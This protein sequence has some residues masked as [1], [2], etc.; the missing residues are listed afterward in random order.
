MGITEGVTEF[1][2]I[3][4]TGHMV[5]VAHILALAE[6]NFVKSFEI[7]IQLGAIAA[8]VLLYAKRVLK[9]WETMKKVLTAFV[10]TGIIG[11]VLYKL[12]KQY[13][14]GNVWVTVIAL[15]A[16]GAAIILL[17][18]KMKITNNRSHGEQLPITNLKDLSYKKAATIGVIQ[19]ISVIPGVSRA[20]ATI[21]G[22]MGMGLTR[23]A[24]TEFSFLLAVP[25]MLAATGLDLVKS[26]HNFSGGE[27]VILAIGFGTAFAAAMTTVKW[28][29]NFVQRHSL[30]GFGVYRIIVAVV[31][32]FIFF[33]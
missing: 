26:G 24:A 31:Y 20:A 2:P 33:R 27:W 28:L 4:S 25:T 32:A 9:D 23:E 17:E 16:G 15:G 7:V 8:V 1:L 11:L 12:I 3:S 18:S 29:I 13:L 10:P 19:A 14:L 5:L 21:L 6:T 30:K 22:G